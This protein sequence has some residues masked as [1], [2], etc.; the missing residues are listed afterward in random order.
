LQPDRHFIDWYGEA[1]YSLTPVAF[2][3]LWWMASL[4]IREAGWS[5]LSLRPLRRRAAGS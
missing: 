1:F 4:S 3:S 2:A 5:P